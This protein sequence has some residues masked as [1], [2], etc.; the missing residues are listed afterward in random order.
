MQYF[1]SQSNQKE[2]A[3]NSLNLIK[4]ICWIFIIFGIISLFISISLNSQILAFIGLGLVFWG[5]ILL[6]IQPEEQS[7][8]ILFEQITNHTLE[9]LNKLVIELDYKGKAL[10][11]P[12]KYFQNPETSKV[13]IS[14]NPE[15]II[16]NPNQLINLENQL[17]ISN[18]KGILI[19]PPGS[20]I[21]KLFEEKLGINLS[22]ANLNYLIQNLP[23]VFTEDLEIAEKLEIDTEQETNSKGNEKIDFGKIKIR[24]KNPIFKNINEKNPKFSQ[25]VNLIGFPISSAIACA[26]TKVTGSPVVISENKFYDNGNIIE[27]TYKI[28][29]FDN[30]EIPEI[31]YKKSIDNVKPLTKTVLEIEENIEEPKKISLKSEKK[32]DQYLNVSQ[33]SKLASISLIIVG[34]ITLFWILQF[35]WN[36]LIE[37]Q[38]SLGLILFS[39]RP[40]EAISL[41]IG[42][43]VIYYILIGLFLVFL[44]LITYFKKGKNF[45]RTFFQPILFEKLFNLILILAGLL[46]IIWISD[47]IFYEILVWDN[48]LIYILFAY[49]QN[50]PIGL[51]IG[52]KV[53]HYLIIGL[54]MLISGTFSYF[55]LNK[56]ISKNIEQ[57][58]IKYHS[59]INPPKY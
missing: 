34:F 10:Y 26:L 5:V 38:K 19:T 30:K 22:Q 33:F 51:G 32:V 7:K 21:L 48:D 53:I 57:K 1:S 16:F 17:F 40:N 12:A 46:I 36:E 35:T 3:N 50:E 39:Y 49:G 13:F 47:L 42:M 6:Y 2:E 15:D 59:T 45:I 9:T 27:V 31:S 4:K 11:L 20:E 44:G 56:N 37:G 28:K 52:M 14:K 24:I 25:I 18:P 55:R 58:S 29:Q 41:G 8:K 43:K 23:K 54:T